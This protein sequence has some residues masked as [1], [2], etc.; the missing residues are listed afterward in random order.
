EEDYLLDKQKKPNTLMKF[1]VLLR[2]MTHETEQQYTY[3][4]LKR[5]Y[6]GE[7]MFATL[8]E[9]KL[10]QPFHAL[11]DL[12]FKENGSEVQIDC[13]LFIGQKIF[14]FELIHYYVNYLIN[15]YRWFISST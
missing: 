11:Y 7:K 9:R 3:E 4:R 8:L 12:Q 15:N 5:G 13:L 6:E 10:S 1:E 14:L 2:Y